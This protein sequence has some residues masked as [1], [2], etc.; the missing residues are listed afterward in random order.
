VP[1]PP[2]DRPGPTPVAQNHVRAVIGPVQRWLVR[3]KCGGKPARTAEPLSVCSNQ[4]SRRVCGELKNLAA[5]RRPTLDLIGPLGQRIAAAAP[6]L[7]FHPGSAHGL[8][9]RGSPRDPRRLRRYRCATPPLKRTMRPF[10]PLAKP[11][12]SCSP[13]WPERELDFVPPTEIVSDP[14]GTSFSRCSVRGMTRLNSSCAAS[15]V[16][17]TPIVLW[18]SGSRR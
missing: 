11:T 1:P 8:T 10:Q 5:R 13:S 16:R 17:C 2:C 9:N 18:P 12:S 4:G 7:Q 14:H 15:A 3:R 6:R